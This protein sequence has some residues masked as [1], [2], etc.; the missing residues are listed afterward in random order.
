MT[1]SSVTFVNKQ[2]TKTVTESVGDINNNNQLKNNWLIN[3]YDIEIPTNIAPIVAYGPKFSYNAKI[4]KS[5]IIDTI[6][7]VESTPKFLEFNN[8]QSDDN[9]NKNSE[10][11]LENSDQITK[12]KNFRNK[13]I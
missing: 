11:Y 12:I 8:K 5:D 10:N 7:N 2:S 3:L 9:S 4:E 13:I 1:C 6:K